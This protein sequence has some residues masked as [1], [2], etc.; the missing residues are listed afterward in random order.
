MSD[1]ANRLYLYALSES[2][3]VQAAL[4]PPKFLSDWQ[5]L[6]RDLLGPLMALNS[7]G[8]LLGIVPLLMWKPQQQDSIISTKTLTS[9]PYIGLL[10]SPPLRSIETEYYRHNDLDQPSKE[11]S[12]SR[13]DILIRRRADKAS[14]TK[15]EQEYN[16]PVPATVTCGR[17]KEVWIHEKVNINSSSL[18]GRYLRH[19]Q[20]AGSGTIQ[21]STLSLYLRSYCGSGR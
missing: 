21:A 20:L 6:F 2:R 1:F 9:R 13:T 12:E 5:R 19:P 15:R 4:S 7:S 10:A 18:G 14:R 11:H 17:R 16:P 8:Q 3:V